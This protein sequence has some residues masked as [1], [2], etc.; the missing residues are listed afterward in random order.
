MSGKRRYQ[1]LK[2]GRKG[3]NAFAYKAIPAELWDVFEGRKFFQASTGKQYGQEAAAIAA[4]LAKGWTKQIEAAKARTVTPVQRDIQRLTKMYQ[5]AV[6]SSAKSDAEDLFTG[7]MQFLNDRAMPPLEMILHGSA[8][9]PNFVEKHKTEKTPFLRHFSDWKAAGRYGGTALKTAIT[10]IEG[11]DTAVGQSIEALRSEHV[12]RWVDTQ[13]GDAANTIRNRLYSIG[14]YWR[15]MT[16][17]GLA[18]RDSKPFLDIEIRGRD[19]DDAKTRF[20][21]ADVPKL[22]TKAATIHLPLYYMVKIAAFS[23]A[24]REA[25]GN[26]KVDDIHLDGAVPFFVIQQDKTE[27]GK[28]QVPIHSEIMGLMRELVKNADADGY[29]IYSTA[30]GEK[31]TGPLGKRFSKMKTAMKY[32]GTMD[33][34]SLR[35]TVIHLFEAA[36]APEGVC[37][38]V[39]GHKKK[40]LTYGTYSGITS[41]EHRRMWLE[42]AV[43][44]PVTA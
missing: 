29:L 22:W 6:G 11:F 28:R 20:D 3:S 42:K 36:E 33:F 5:Q 10:H 1:Y 39:V 9:D 38:D 13:T 37:K 26:I 25:I 32:D 15:W 31:R 24:R 23:G 17:R 7:I 44:Y 43:R 21:P 2:E 19:D 34:H 35:R 40:S 4:T 14:N 41:L 18:P 12:Q 8:D 30:T 27:A 16:Q